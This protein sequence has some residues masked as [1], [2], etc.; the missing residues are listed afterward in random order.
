MRPFS[1]PSTLTSVLAC[2]GFGLLSPACGSSGD[3]GGHAPKNLQYTVPA[4][5]YAR[6]VG[7]DPNTPSVKG[8]VTSYWVEPALP[9]G[10]ALDP[11]TGVITGAPDAVSDLGKFTVF[12]KNKHGKTSTQLS[13]GVALPSRFAIV[14]QTLDETLSVF[15]GAAEPGEWRPNGFFARADATQRL[16]AVVAHPSGRFVYALDDATNDVALYSIDPKTGELSA[17]GIFP[18]G[19]GPWSLSFDAAG[20]HGYLLCRAD[21]TVESYAIDHAT[22]AVTP[23][24]APIFLGGGP[25]AMHLDASS[26]FLYV[27]ETWRSKVQALALDATTHLPT[28]RGAAIASGETPVDLEIDPA[29][30]FLYTANLRSH[31]L[32]R[33]AI[34]ATTGELSSL[35]SVGTGVF[36]SDV[37]ID[38]TG[39]FLYVCESGDDAIHGFAIDPATGALTALAAGRKAGTRPISLTFEST[40]D[41]LHVLD[42]DGNRVWTFPV[43]RATGALGDPR[44]MGTRDQPM[45]LALIQDNH[46]AVPRSRFVYVANG[47]SHDLSVYAANNTNGA[48]HTITASVFSPGSPRVALATPNGRFVYS[49]TSGAD[50]A[51][52]F[53]VDAVTGELTSVG[54]PSPLASTPVAGVIDPSGRFLFALSADDDLVQCF[55][56]NPTNGTLA[57][58]GSANTGSGPSALA[59]DSTGRFLYVANHA[60]SSISFFRIDPRNGALTQTQPESSVNGFPSAISCHPDGRHLYLV[61]E[62]SGTALKL[63]IDAVTGELSSPVPQS[64]GVWPTAIAVDARGRFAY[65]A[66]RTNSGFGDLTYYDIDNATGDLTPIGSAITGLGPIA[67]VG[68]PSG[69]F[70]YVLNETDDTVTVYAVNQ[71]NGA[72]LLATS[73]STGVAPRSI[74]IIGALE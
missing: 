62:Q 66:N 48:L 13:L 9:N 32:S 25:Q 11:K 12:A 17:G 63:D 36:P 53:A 71:T 30:R 47:G 73:I 69:R 18:T 61:L 34:D 5:V 51:R 45:T 72:P 65:S 29:G 4:A 21:E 3:D 39:R 23:I 20:C 8:K 58:R 37:A 60:A 1:F 74:A 50:T 35:D 41:Q 59:I 27:A 6:G 10:L 19:N 2:L 54:W 22:G 67:A 7:I 56:I 15:A 28:L 64:S 33:F 26:R 40:G 70:L 31:D 16:R 49:L 68:D 55:E 43:D 57:L 38:P 14:G 46:A 42:I 44:A 52:G 24:G